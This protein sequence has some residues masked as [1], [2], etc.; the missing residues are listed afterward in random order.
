MIVVSDTTPLNYLLLVDA[1]DVL[2]Q[3]F[4]EVCVPDQ[5]LKELQHE[6]TPLVVRRWAALPPGWLKPMTPNTT[7]P[8]T[9]RLDRGE[10]EAI[11]L[12][13]EIGASAILI[14]ERKATKIAQEEGLTVVRTLTLL[15][16]AAERN[17]LDLPA[18][19]KKLQAT[20][21]RIPPEKIAAACERDAARKAAEQR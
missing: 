14:D 17:L 18:T 11:S 7:L 16:L 3:L 15:E 1:I 13:R 19:L 20:N 9:S 6:R 8:S 21:F 5:V 4:G 12:A 2:P 10:A